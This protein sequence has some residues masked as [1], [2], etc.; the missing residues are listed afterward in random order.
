MADNVASLAHYVFG[1]IRE[2]MKG[3]PMSDK[4]V[5]Q[6]VPVP[7]DFGRLAD[8][9]AE[10]KFLAE[11]AARYRLATEEDALLFLDKAT[12]EELAELAT[13]A[14][15]IRLERLY[16]K[17]YRLICDDDFADTWESTWI[18]GLLLAM[19]HADFNFH[20]L[21]GDERDSWEIHGCS[22]EEWSRRI[23][24][25]TIGKEPS[26]SG[27]TR[28]MCTYAYY[29]DFYNRILHFRAD[30]VDNFMRDLEMAIN[31]HGF[32]IWGEYNNTGAD[33]EVYDTSCSAS[34]A[35]LVEDI[36]MIV[37]QQYCYVK[38]YERKNVTGEQ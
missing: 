10:L 37:N 20:D 23:A 16:P 24:Y 38:R 12:E 8:L 18:G 9:P 25:R 6:A 36:I 2:S 21:Y 19:D 22:D 26:I 1:G 3:A 32:R 14:E 15:R 5:Y 29:L 28:G 7:G 30:T 31:S 27:H 33:L 17:I 34:R 13:L 11:P 4:E 35:K